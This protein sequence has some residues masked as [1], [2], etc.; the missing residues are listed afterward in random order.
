MGALSPNRWES[1]D[2][3]L[4]FENAIR[5]GKGLQV[6]NI[7]RDIPA[8][9]KIGRCY[10]PLE[11]LSPTG[12]TPADLLDPANITRFR[13]IYD[14]LLQ[15]AQDHLAAGWEYTNTLPF[16]WFRIR[17]ACAWPILIGLRTI[18]YLR[19]Q[20]P[21][22]AANRIKASRAEVKSLMLGTLLRYPFP[23]LWR[24]QYARAL[25]LAQGKN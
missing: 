11:L 16:G 2:D 17:L 14:Q 25:T 3:K 15:R 19:R 5:F 7:L 9:L 13:P 6:V 21:L 1:P 10:I 4:L 23:T 18:A 24:N 8:D 20:N 22:D 12:L